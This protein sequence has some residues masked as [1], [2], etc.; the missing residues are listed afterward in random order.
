VLTSSA[1]T[2]LRLVNSRLFACVCVCVCDV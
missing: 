1:S 2:M